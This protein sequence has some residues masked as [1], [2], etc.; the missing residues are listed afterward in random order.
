MTNLPTCI[1]ITDDDPLTLKALNR[2]LIDVGY[3]VCSASNGEQTLKLAEEKHPDLILMDV[4]LPDIEGTEVCRRLKADARTA[5]I[6]VVLLSGVRTSSDEQSEGMEGGADGYIARPIANRE[7]LARIQAYLRIKT[8]EQ[9]LMEH[10]RS[11][12]REV[13]ERK[14]AEDAVKTSEKRFHALIEKSSDAI[15]LLDEKGIA[16]YDSPAAPGML[17]YAPDDWIGHNIFALIHPDDLPGIQVIFQK[18]V[19]TPGAR[20]HSTLRLRHKS[21]AWLW[22]EAVATNFLAET[23]VKA[24]VLNYRDIT[25]RRHAEETLRET[26]A[27]LRAILTNAPITIFATDS[28]GVFTLSEGKGLERVGLKPGENIGISALD[29]YGSFPFVEHTGKVTDGKDVI[30]RALA[31]ETMIAESKLGEAF[32]ENHIG[33][34]LDKDGNVIGIVGVATDI[35]ERKQA[36]D[37]IKKQLAELQRWHNATLGRELRILDLKREV[38]ELLG[39]AGQPPRY[40]SAESE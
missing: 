1:L 18:L 10:A 8:A 40:P 9:K 2:L 27:Q 33:P 7:L 4:I 14:Q 24:I 25:E 20:A 31:G 36:E 23:S 29:L 12:E 21:G 37:E 28:H 17:G 11:L 26:E 39:G 19:E 38:N 5:D 3:E 16:L 32:F 15:T 30:R 6:F 35:T 13:T 34:I 22:I